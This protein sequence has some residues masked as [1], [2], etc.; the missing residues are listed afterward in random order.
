VV[1][2]GNRKG[3]VPWSTAAPEAFFKMR[4][5]PDKVLDTED[6]EATVILAALACE[7]G[8]LDEMRKFLAM[9]QGHAGED[10]SRANVIRSLFG[11]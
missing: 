5:F 7:L 2:D 10:E 1:F 8:K 9:A 3:T 4:V 11:K 6:F